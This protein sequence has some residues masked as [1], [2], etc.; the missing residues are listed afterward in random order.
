MQVPSGIEMMISR[1]LKSAGIDPTIVENLANGLM[2]G[3]AQGLQNDQRIMAQNRRI[4][5]LLE[6]QLENSGVSIP[7]IREDETYDDGSS[8]GSGPNGNAPH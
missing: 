8:G 4:I 1:L 5:R 2:G 6:T 3:I 7:E